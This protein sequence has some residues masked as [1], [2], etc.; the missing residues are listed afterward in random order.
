MFS[1]I[2]SHLIQMLKEVNGYLTITI[3]LAIALFMIVID[4]PVYKRKGYLKEVK[5]IKVIS[6]SYIALGGIMYILLL[7]I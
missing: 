7:I 5:I 2:L 4:M 6:Y 3:I 1:K